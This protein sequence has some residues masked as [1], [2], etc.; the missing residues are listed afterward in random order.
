MA[1][2][3]LGVLV[4]VLLLVGSAAGRRSPPPLR[5]GSLASQISVGPGV[6]Q[7][8]TVTSSGWSSTR[9]SLR[10]WRKRD[11]DWRLVRGP[12]RTRLGWNGFVRAQDRQQSTGTTPAGRFTM[13]SAFGNRA[14]PGSGLR[15]RRVDG[16]DFWPYEP[17]DPATYNI[18]QPSKARTARWRADYRRAARRLRLRV[19]LQQS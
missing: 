17:R 8:V 4:T 16:N 6:R 11:G 13:R 1:R 3:R 5:R 18:F 12:I 9:A 10:V 2:G 19:R 15:Y 14:D 7:M